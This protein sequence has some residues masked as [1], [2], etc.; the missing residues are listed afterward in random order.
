M[1]DLLSGA[2]QMASERNV[3][4]HQLLTP[5]E[6]EVLRLLIARWSNREIAEEL[7]I[8]IR[9]VESHVDHIFRKLGVTSREEARGRVARISGISVGNTDDEGQL[10]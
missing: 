7:Y 4:P 2:G 3:D 5:R 8:S 10:A 6:H 9:T 1:I